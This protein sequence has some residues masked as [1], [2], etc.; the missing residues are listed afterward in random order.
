LSTGVEVRDPRAWLY[1]IIHNAAVSTERRRRPIAGEIEETVSANGADHEAE[2]RMAAREALEGLAALPPMQRDVLVSTAVDGLSHEEVAEALGLTSGAVRGLVYRARATLR[3][4]AA[5]VLPGPLIS[6]S[7]RAAER[8]GSLGVVETL[9]GGG[10]AGLGA[11]MLKG[12]AIAVTAGAIATAGIATHADHRP[13]GQ[14][15]GESSSTAQIRS[16]SS[17]GVATL[18]RDKLVSDSTGPAAGSP[19]EASGGGD[20][21]TSGGR[22][23]RAS[24]LDDHGGGHGR[25]GPEDHGADRSRGSGASREDRDGGGRGSRGGPGPSSG[26][27]SSGEST[28]SRGS[29]RSLGGSRLSSGGS[30]GD[31]VP[32]GASSGGPRRS[33]AS[34]SGGPSPSGGSSRGGSSGSGSPAGGPAASSSPGGDDVSAGSSES[35][36]SS[37]GRE[38]G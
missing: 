9:A 30:G 16:R 12:G 21:R 17:S 6:W 18:A 35:G 10:S 27:R 26:D 36:S 37:A 4:A 19:G 7:L 32:S 28:S 5:A 25:G 33:G 31:P 2:R 22:H 11:L 13:G 24:R 3:A 14:A 34:P 38:P 23:R 29:N 20:R 8:G 1:R 15:A